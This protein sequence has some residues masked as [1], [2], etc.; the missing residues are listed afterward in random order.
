MKGFD[1][2]LKICTWEPWEICTW[3]TWGICTW[4]TWGICTC[5]PWGICTWETWGICTWETWGM[6]TWELGKYVRGN[7][8][9][10]LHKNL[11]EYILEEYLNK[12]SNGNSISI[13]KPYNFIN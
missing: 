4:E 8:E 11:W 12:N 13:R 1:L 7:R 5:E 3:E 6:C 10:H 2:R 9:K